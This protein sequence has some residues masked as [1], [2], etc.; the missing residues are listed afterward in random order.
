MAILAVGIVAI[1]AASAFFFLRRRKRGA[2][3]DK[4]LPPIPVNVL[5]KG[6]DEDMK[7]SPIDSPTTPQELHSRPVEELSTPYN[8]PRDLKKPI[9]SGP[10]EM[11]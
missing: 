2:P 6:P 3:K 5:E 4:E 9:E 10:H 7:K 11:Q 1:I 8:E